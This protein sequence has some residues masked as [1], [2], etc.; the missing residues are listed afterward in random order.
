M[1]TGLQIGVLIEGMEGQPQAEAVRQRD[2]LFHCIAM[3]QLAIDD[4]GG[5]VV[6][7]VLRQ[8]MT[9]V[10]GGV[11]Q[12]VLRRPRQGAIQHALERLVG[13]IA[14][15]EGQVIAIDD[16]AM[17]L[18]GQL[19]DQRRQCRQVVAIDLDQAQPLTAQG[20]EQCADQR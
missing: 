9:T 18:L 1:L 20:I 16:E 5:L 3:M 11:Q 12:H 17:R 14:A 13:V 2:L 19:G 7:H 6:A 4:V 8:Q 10:G 15:L